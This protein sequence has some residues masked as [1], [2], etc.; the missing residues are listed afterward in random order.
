[1]EA[2]LGGTSQ[3]RAKGSPLASLRLSWLLMLYLYNVPFPIPGIHP[4]QMPVPSGRRNSLC[5]FSFQKLKLP[6]TE[7][8]K[9]LGAQTAKN[10]PHSPFSCMGWLPSLLYSLKCL[11]ARI[12]SISKSVRRV[13]GLTFCIFLYYD[14]LFLLDRMGHKGKNFSKLASRNCKHRDLWHKSPLPINL[15][16]TS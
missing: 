10:V 1:M 11:P 13:C 8:S 3:K 14:C 12:S 2:V 5:V 6:T 16:E 9:A 4:S 7:T 15:F